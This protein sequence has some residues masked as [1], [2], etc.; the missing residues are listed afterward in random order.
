MWIKKVKLFFYQKRKS[1][2]YRNVCGVVF[3]ALTVF[4]GF[5]LFYYHPGSECSSGT[6][7]Y[8]GNIGCSLAAS[9]RQSLGISAFLLLP[10]LVVFLCMIVAELRT[11]V[12]IVKL[13]GC[14]FVLLCCTIFL[15]VFSGF[16]SMSTEYIG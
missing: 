4:I 8:I 2:L 16:F 9:L 1:K 11:R 3:F 12:I 6:K 5:S 13:A 10:V 7:E 14:L 15:S